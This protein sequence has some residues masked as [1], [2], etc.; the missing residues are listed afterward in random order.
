MRPRRGYGSVLG[1]VSR[2]HFLR[3]I[4]GGALAVVA[5]GALGGL[6]W[7]AV[8]AARTHVA[9]RNQPVGVARVDQALAI[10]LSAA[11]KHRTCTLPSLAEKGDSVVVG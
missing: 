6:T 1:G 9:A 4:G 3:R 8:E 5:I 7:P 11:H 2:Q 10:Y